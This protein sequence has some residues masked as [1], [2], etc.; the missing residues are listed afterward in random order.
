LTHTAQDFYAHSNY[1]D[2]WLARQS[3]KV[4]PQEV[5]P[6]DV[7]LIHSSALRS[8]KVYWLEALTFIV[9][10]RSLVMRLLPRDA[11]AWTNIDSPERGPNFPYAFQAAVKRTKIEFERTIRDLPQNLFGLFVDK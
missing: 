9:P 5:H 4:T 6:M 1:I 7:E 10:L 11:H 2:L 8:G 3:A